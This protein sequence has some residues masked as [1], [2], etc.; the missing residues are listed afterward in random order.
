MKFTT[1]KLVT[2]ARATHAHA[3]E[4]F[5][6]ITAI[7]R[8]TILM[9]ANVFKYMWIAN[10]GNY[11]VNRYTWSLCFYRVRCNYIIRIRIYEFQSISS[12][13]LLYGRIVV[14]CVSCW[15]YELLLSVKCV[16]N[17]LDDC[18]K[19]IHMFKFLQVFLRNKP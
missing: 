13:N 15:F 2:N 19:I 5:P 8:K 9:L 16:T 17:C 7:T 4:C 14:G 18:Y 10:V 6:S 11:I 12:V 1:V 3:S